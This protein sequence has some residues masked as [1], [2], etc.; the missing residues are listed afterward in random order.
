MLC[1]D[2]GP[3][4][5]MRPMRGLRKPGYLVHPSVVMLVLATMRITLLSRPSLPMLGTVPPPLL[6]PLPT[7]LERVL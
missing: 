3:S 4:R 5:R 6:D 7:H 1:S 2:Q